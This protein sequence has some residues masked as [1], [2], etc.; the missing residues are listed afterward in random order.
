[1][2]ISKRGISPLIATVLIVGFTIALA[3]I[4]I[5]WGQ[6]FTRQLQQG[7]EASSNQQII[8]A[9]EVVFQITK[10]CRAGTPNVSFIVKN[11]GT[12]NIVEW[13][14]RYYNGADNV[15]QSTITTPVNSLDI[16]TIVDGVKAPA[17]WAGVKLVELIPVIRIENQ[18]VVCANNVQKFGDRAFEIVL[19]TC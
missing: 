10:A 17:T 6:S 2:G 1:M 9:T 19:P 12:R 8:C 13:R 16:I 18:N 11:D 7:T 14:A 15:G 5:T 3:A 4:V